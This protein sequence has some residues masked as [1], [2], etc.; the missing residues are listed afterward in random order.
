[1]SASKNPVTQKPLEVS[2]QL[3]SLPGKPMAVAFFPSPARLLTEWNEKAVQQAGD[4]PWLERLQTMVSEGSSLMTALNGPTVLAVYGDPDVD[5]EPR[6]LLRV[7]GGTEEQ[8]NPWVNDFLPE[9]AER[10]VETSG[11][12]LIERRGV[13]GVLYYGGYPGGWL[14]SNNLQLATSSLMGSPGELP[15]SIATG[16]KQ[17]CHDNPQVF[18]GVDLTAVLKQAP[19]EILSAL[20]LDRIDGL[21]ITLSKS[22]GRVQ[23]SLFL[24]TQSPHKGVLTLFDGPRLKPDAVG[25]TPRSLEALSLWSVDLVR[26]WRELLPALP[27]QASSQMKMFEQMMGMNIEKDLLGALGTKMVSWT[28]SLGSGPP[29]TLVALELRDREKFR[30][31]VHDLTTRT[32]GS[33][34]WSRGPNGEDVIGMAGGMTADH[35][36]LVAMTDDT[37]YLSKTGR[38]LKAWL[39]GKIPK[40]TQ[41][42]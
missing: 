36:P 7:K 38:D 12:H 34:A 35:M 32:P 20:G 5:K 30:K 1:M 22:R 19:P 31:Q 14:A 21:C 23:D 33:V 9:G 15:Q 25:E 8:L 10:V 24:V 2:K 29:T 42:Q 26:V 39:S 27:P 3:T 13:S 11:G 41:P 40:G 17:L 6:V 37:L 16:W 18:V 4:A 28:Y